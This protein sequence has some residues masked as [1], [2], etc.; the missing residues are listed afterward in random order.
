MAFSGFAHPLYFTIFVEWKYPDEYFF[1]SMQTVREDDTSQ[2]FL[3][4][5]SQTVTSTKLAPFSV[6]V[7][8]S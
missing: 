5:L 3:S 7:D 8:V 1:L 6:A 4:P 2:F